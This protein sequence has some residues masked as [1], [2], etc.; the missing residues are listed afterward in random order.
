MK[1]QSLFLLSALIAGAGF[2]LAGF[3]PGPGIQFVDVTQKAGIRFSHNS[4]HTGKK[5]MPETVGSGCAFID[6][7]GDGW[8][9]ILLINGKDFTSSGHRSLPG[10][11][12]NNHDGTFTDVTSG[13]GLDVEMY[14]F[15]VSV[16]DY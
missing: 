3:V 12:H 11:Y 16:A 1:S 9:D 15:G 2:S 7:D 8:A 6:L 10:F 13:S 5:L 4:G 14:G